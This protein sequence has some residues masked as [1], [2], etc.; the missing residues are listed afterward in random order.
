MMDRSQLAVSAILIGFVIA[1]MGVSFAVLAEIARHDQMRVADRV[2][3]VAALQL[4]TRERERY[5]KEWRADLYYVSLEGG[6]PLRWSI[7]ILAAGCAGGRVPVRV[8]KFMLYNPILLTSESTVIY[9]A[10]SRMYPRYMGFVVVI[11]LITAIGLNSPREVQSRANGIRMWIV[12]LLV[13]LG[14]LAIGLY[15]QSRR[16]KVISPTR[17][18]LFATFLVIRLTGGS[19]VPSGRSTRL[20]RR[21]LAPTRYVLSR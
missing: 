16:R 10:M 2:I 17:G 6:S 15:M 11:L 4:P 20:G 3:R 21:Q 13:I 18:L 8:V 14:G 19:I 5:V 7:G 12:S 9:L 1:P